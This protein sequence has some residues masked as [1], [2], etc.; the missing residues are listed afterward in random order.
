M[1]ST[2]KN[3][4]NFRRDEYVQLSVCEAAFSSMITVKKCRTRLMPDL[5]LKFT[6]IVPNIAGLYSGK[7]AHLSHNDVMRNRHES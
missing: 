3:L 5:R 6:K 1:L 2:L 7:Q 4:K